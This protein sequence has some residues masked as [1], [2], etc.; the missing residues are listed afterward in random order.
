M[1]GKL[2]IAFVYPFMKI[3]DY[4]SLD[5]VLAEYHKLFFLVIAIIYFILDYFLIRK[6]FDRIVKDFDKKSENEIASL[7]LYDY[8]IKFMIIALN[9]IFL[10]W[11]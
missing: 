8:I 7:R 9:L 4:L 10:F 3:L 5:Y 11:I 1:F 6:K 2:S